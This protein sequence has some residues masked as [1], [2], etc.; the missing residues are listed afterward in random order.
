MADLKAVAARTIFQRICSVGVAAADCSVG[1]AA[2][3]G[4]V[5]IKGT[6]ST[7]GVGAAGCS[8]G[9]AATVGLV[10]VMV[11]GCLVGIL[12]TG[13]AIVQHSLTSHLTSLS[14]NLYQLWQQSS[15]QMQMVMPSLEKKK[16]I[17]KSINVILTLQC[18]A[19]SS[20]KHK[21]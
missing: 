21:K 8:D 11:N 10:A 19:L 16:K 6:N 14:I 12:A 18:T 15:R 13:D 7:V 1:V 5:D 20:D 4:L 17:H 3:V 2:T 9:D